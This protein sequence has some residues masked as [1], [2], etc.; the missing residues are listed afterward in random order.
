MV[1]PERSPYLT[2]IPPDHGPHTGSVCPARFEAIGSLT[3]LL[4]LDLSGTRLD[5]AGASRLAALKRLRCLNLGHTRV[6]DAGLVHLAGLDQLEKLYPDGC[7]V[8]GRGLENLM[9]LTRLHTLD[10]SGTD[11]DDAG[12]EVRGDDAARVP[13]S[14]AHASD[15][16]R[17]RSPLGTQIPQPHLH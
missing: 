15:Q 5:D 1:S 7:R 13:R 17:A 4:E 10:L 16:R 12:L 14:P 9:G 6:T 3:S 8:T 11:V 2:P